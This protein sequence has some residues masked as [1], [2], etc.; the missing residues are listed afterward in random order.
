MSV[1]S[2][3]YEVFTARFYRPRDGE[4]AE[5]QTLV[6]VQ[7]AVPCAQGKLDGYRVSAAG[8]RAV[9]ARWGHG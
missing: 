6:A 9:M 3:L 8:Y 1:A 7:L 5:C 4:Q 2:L